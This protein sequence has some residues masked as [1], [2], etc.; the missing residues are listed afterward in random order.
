MSRV[1]QDVKPQLPF[2]LISLMAAPTTAHISAA[3][4]HS[5]RHP[6]CWGKSPCEITL[7]LTQSERHQSKDAKPA[8]QKWKTIEK[9]EAIES[10]KWGRNI[11]RTGQQ[12]IIENG[13]QSYPTGGQ[14][15]TWVWMEYFLQR[16][17]TVIW[18]HSSISLIIYLLQKNEKMAKEKHCRHH[19]IDMMSR[20]QV[21]S[22]LN[23]IIKMQIENEK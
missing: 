14:W 7:K 18:R 2:S 9:K 13:R 10:R 17:R 3:C 15:N 5:D 6:V 11:S 1:Q 23:P 16:Q 12:V 8:Q 19:R 22:V 4:R 20:L 21:A